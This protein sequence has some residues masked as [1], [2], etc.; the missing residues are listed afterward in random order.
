ML[1]TYMSPIKFETRA[2]LV[3]ASCRDRKW[4]LVS[5]KDE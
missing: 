5:V 4:K 2:G 1:N 3:Q